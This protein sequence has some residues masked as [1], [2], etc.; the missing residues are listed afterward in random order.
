MPNPTPRPKKGRSSEE[1]NH[2]V[3]MSFGIISE[4]RCNACQSPFR[5]AIDRMIALGVS[6][7]EISRSLDGEVSR[8]S[9][10]GHAKNHLDFNDAA[11][12]RI[13]EQ[14][15]DQAAESREISIQGVAQ[16]RAM[17]RTA[18]LRAHEGLVTGT[19]AVEIKDALAITQYLD[20]VDGQDASAKIQEYEIQFNA[21]M[22]AMKELT[23]ETVWA[24]ILNRA[25]EIVAEGGGPP[26]QIEQ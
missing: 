9:I 10:S 11:I 3:P 14:E 13:V 19:T 25:R 2:P 8:A 21:F 22:M 26:E 20:K 4:P 12:A 5:G 24:T 15:I 1:D 23:S 17:L 18:L 16:R 7:S 6:H